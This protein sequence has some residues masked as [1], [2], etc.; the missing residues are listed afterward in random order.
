MSAGQNDLAID[1]ILDR[2]IAP[3]GISGGRAASAFLGELHSLATEMVTHFAT[4]VVPCG[5]LPGE[6]LH[7]DVT[8]IT[9][10][11][12]VL[13]REMLDSRRPPT[14]SQ[15]AAVRTA[16]AQ[17]AREGVPL[18]TIIGTYYEGFRIGFDLVIG[19]VT[20]D[21][22]A[23]VVAGT[24]LVLQLLQA[25]NT[26]VAAAYAD[27]QREVAREHQTSMQALVSALLSGHGVTSIARTTGIR[28]HDSY[29]VAA[30]MIPRHPDERN[31]RVDP[32]IAARRKLRRVQAGLA[33]AFDSHALA[34]L[35]PQGGT[36]L[37]PLDP[38]L[39]RLTGETL[40]IL[41]AA[42]EVELTA[43]VVDTS[44]ELIPAAAEDAH[45]LLDLVRGMGRSAGLYRLA[46]LA[47]EY[48]LTRPGPA[49]DQLADVLAPLEPHPELMATLRAYVAAGLNRKAAGRRLNVHPNTVDYRLRRVA[50]VTGLDLTTAEGILRAR[51]AMLAADL[52]HDRRAS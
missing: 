16:S 45:E 27:E 35:N 7:G 31:P 4:N 42:A 26:A 10:D 36:L 13:V 43:T 14:D 30:V 19:H 8:S 28:V 9:R 2:R 22:L 5:T 49:R 24:R 32:R 11:C 48:Q 3:I 18:E 23:E 20:A 12:L 52:P 29:Q 38:E 44:T 25:I 15:L 33:G 40:E 21:D 37:I 34:L 51:V 6:E 41:S 39:P 46:D 50:A 17:W 47:I 1:S